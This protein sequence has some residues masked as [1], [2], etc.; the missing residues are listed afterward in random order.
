MEDWAEAE[1]HRTTLYQYQLSLDM[2]IHN[3]RANKNPVVQVQRVFAAIKLV[4]SLL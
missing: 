1:F 2:G 4:A 3:S